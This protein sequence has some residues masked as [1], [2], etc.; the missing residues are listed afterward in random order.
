[1]SNRKLGAGDTMVDKT[2]MVPVLIL[3]SKLSSWFFLLGFR[4]Y[5]HNVFCIGILQI[6]CFAF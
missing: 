5:T 4:S 1:M 2:D 6:T 3:Y